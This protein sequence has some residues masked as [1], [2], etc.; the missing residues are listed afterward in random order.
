MM[1]PW[2]KAGSDKIVGF[3]TVGFLGDMLNDL[4]PRSASEQFDANYQHGG[5][6]RPFKGFV[7]QGDGKL[8]FPGDPAYKPVATARLRDERI[9][10]YPYGWVMIQQTDGSYEISRMD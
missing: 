1:V 9:T 4:D 6:W 7:L 10:L 8:K 3:E 2:I 5:G